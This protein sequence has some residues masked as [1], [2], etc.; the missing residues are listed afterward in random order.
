MSRRRG[1]SL[2]PSLFPFL[3]VLVCTLGTLILLLALVAQNA[4]ETVERQSPAKATS[5]S[6]AKAPGPSP[7]L[8]SDTVEAL[9]REEQFRVGQLVTFREQQTEDLERRRDELTHLEDHMDRLRKELQAISK[10]VDRAT[11]VTQ[12]SKIDESEL[13]ELRR[14]IKEQEEIVGHLKAEAADQ[15]PRV[16]IVP[17]KGP[18]GTDRRPIYLECNRDGIT[19]WPEGSRLTMTELENAAYSANP[20]DAALRAI[21]L[22]ALQNYGD[23]VSPYPM[24]LVR[25]DGIEAYATARR[26]M[27]DWDDQFGY[28]L[29]PAAV[30]L[31]YGKFDPKLKR[32]VDIAIRTAVSQQTSRRAIAARFGGGGNSNFGVTTPAGRRGSRLPVLSAAQLDQQGRSSGYG[33]LR[34]SRATVGSSNRT[35]PYARAT[36]GSG[37]NNGAYSSGGPYGNAATPGDEVAAAARNWAEQMKR[38]GQEMRQNGNSSTTPDGSGTIHSNIASLSGAATDANPL[39]NRG[40]TT[41][42]TGTNASSESNQFQSPSPDQNQNLTNQIANNKLSLSHGSRDSSN[43]TRT[44]SGGSANRLPPNANTGGQS[45]TVPT[46]MSQSATMSSKQRPSGTPS[47][48]PPINSRERT[49]ELVKRQGREWAL[50]PH[51]AGMQGGEVVRSLR[52]ECYPDRL[53]LPSSNTGPLEIFGLATE[54]IDSATLRLATSLRDRIDRWG[55]ALPGARWKP[56]LEVLVHPGGEVR[57]EQLRTLMTDSG[58]DVVGRSAR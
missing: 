7:Q 38:A 35:N 19:I 27:R 29:V 56:R 33:S 34:E 44:G 14:Q 31:G 30:K 49:K 50:P 55:P 13:A 57:F 16:V 22:H 36:I 18:N 6:V 47:Q 21:R 32:K 46:T 43:Q 26:A 20:L 40:E 17:H 51:L 5:E 11:G 58:I 2:A 8:T 10:E 37:L 48:A 24:L 1:Q 3:A 25:P 23:P 12:N 4:T 53:I 39:A 42:G 45:G 9:L 52:A 28:E 41:N 15:S 54:D